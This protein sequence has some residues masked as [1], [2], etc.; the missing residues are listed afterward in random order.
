ME[1]SQWCVIIFLQEIIMVRVHILLERL[2]NHHQ[3]PLRAQT[4]KQIPPQSFVPTLTI[5][6]YFGRL[7]LQFVLS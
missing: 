1:S 2:H 3:N 6:S 5:Q 7:W 4:Q